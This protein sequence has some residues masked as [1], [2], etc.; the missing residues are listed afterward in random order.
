M[1]SLV[2]TI[3]PPKSLGACVDKYQEMRQARLELERKADAM[4]QLEVQM[5][6]HIV[7]NIPQGDGGA[8]GK[9]FK[10]VRY[11][12]PQYSIKDDAAFYEYVRKTN[13]FDLLNRALNRRAVR[14]RMEDPKFL[15]RFP[16]GVPGVQHFNA[17]KL[18]ITKI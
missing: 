7:K 1:P 6:E 14:E 11:I 2:K 16:K 17:V 9:K 8:V 3:K 18:S 13:S 15:K 10:A 12:E 4:K 5:F